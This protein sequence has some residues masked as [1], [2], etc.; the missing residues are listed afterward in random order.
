MDPGFAPVKPGLTLRQNLQETA[1]RNRILDDYC[2]EL[3][4]DPADIIRSLLIFPRASDVPFDSD[5]AFHDFVGRYRAAGIDEFIL[6]WW[7]EE[8]IEYGYDRGVVERCADREML[9]HLAAETIPTLK[10]ATEH[11][12]P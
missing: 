9:E 1:R 11:P 4:R 6:Y 3:G 12:K 7:R 2:S 5:E 10:A 8:A